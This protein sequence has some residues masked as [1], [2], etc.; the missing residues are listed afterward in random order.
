MQESNDIG[1]TFLRA[2]MLAEPGRTRSLD[3][4]EQYADL[5]VDLA[6]QV[7]GQ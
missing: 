3:V 4:L 5:A 6:N 2:Q 1:T 7:P